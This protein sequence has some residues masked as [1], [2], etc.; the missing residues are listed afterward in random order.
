MFDELHTSFILDEFCKF[1]LNAR[2]CIVFKENNKTHQKIFFLE[3]TLG[4]FRVFFFAS[5]G[6]KE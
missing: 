1:R 6:S 4:F 3:G 5:P 2:K